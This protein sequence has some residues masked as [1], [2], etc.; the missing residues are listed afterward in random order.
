M[1]KDLYEKQW[2]AY[3]FGPQLT[4]YRKLK[5]IERPSEGE[6][7]EQRYLKIYVYINAII[8]NT[9]YKL[10]KILQNLLIINAF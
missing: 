7:K 2:N 6:T 9:I 5:N 8:F 3:R 4:K 10:I 1:E